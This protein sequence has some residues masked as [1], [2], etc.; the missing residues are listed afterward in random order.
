MGRNSNFGVN[1][2][3]TLGG[4]IVITRWIFNA[5]IFIPKKWEIM[6]IVHFGKKG[7]FTV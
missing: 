2:P 1:F 6:K 5:L 7:A 3:R 4:N